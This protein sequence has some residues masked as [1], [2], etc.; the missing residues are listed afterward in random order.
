MKTKKRKATIIEPSGN[1]AG[2]TVADA[3]AKELLNPSPPPPD[4]KLNGSER[5]Q[6]NKQLSLVDQLRLA[7]SDELDRSLDQ[8]LRIHNEL[9]AQRNKLRQL[10]ASFGLSRGLDFAN[11]EFDV[12]TLQF[13]S[14]QASAP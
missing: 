5:E 7:Q 8:L 4:L 14:R 10:G 2:S 11:Y 1:G 6:W 13:V 9:N 3:V 12:D